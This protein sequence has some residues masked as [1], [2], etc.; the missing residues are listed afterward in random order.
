[1]RY[2]LRVYQVQ[3]DGKGQQQLFDLKNGELP[4]EATE[5]GTLRAACAVGR[6]L[7]ADDVHKNVK[8]FNAVHWAFFISKKPK[9]LVML[10]VS[11][12]RAV[13]V[14]LIK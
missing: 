3:E 5:F 13:Y 6:Q 9:D 2:V 11:T 8:T 4:M 10:G 1:M 14:R 12:K 7:F